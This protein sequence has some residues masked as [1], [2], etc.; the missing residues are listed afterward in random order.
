MNLFYY[1][2]LAGL[3]GALLVNGLTYFCRFVG[4]RV[5]T[6]WEIA[7]SVFVNDRLIHST[8]GIALGLAGSIAL[9]TACALL[10]AFVLKWTGANKAWL[11]GIICAD[12]LGFITMGL[13]MRLLDIWPQIRDEPETN[14]EAL[15]G[16]TM[17]G[18]VQAVLIKKWQQEMLR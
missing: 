3:I 18:I 14:I 15:F 5:S 17:L 11:K 13:F 1:S 12:A 16:L 2:T 7:A 9:S 10:I 8:A 4:V 6:P